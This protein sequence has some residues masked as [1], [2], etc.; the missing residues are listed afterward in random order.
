MRTKELPQHAA[1]WCPTCQASE[2]FHCPSCVSS[3]LP[4]ESDGYARPSAHQTREELLAEMNS[5]RFFTD[6]GGRY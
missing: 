2:Y 3:Q 4:N 5:R 1:K 6:Q